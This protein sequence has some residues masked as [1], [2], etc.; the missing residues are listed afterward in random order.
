MSED[1]RRG[2]MLHLLCGRVAAGKSTLAARLAA[3]DRAIVIAEDTWL[4][5]LY[6]G[7]ITTV[8]AYVE[9]AARLRALMG[10]H[11]A[12]LLRG[13]LS[14]VLDFPANTPATRVWMREIVERSGANHR[15][16]VLD[17]PI[18]VCRA[19]MHARNAAGAHEYAP[20][21]AEFDH[22]SSFFVPP[23]ADEGFDIVIHRP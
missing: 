22:I 8:A 7:E 16:H 2:A 9:R 10:P 19:R 21:D 23:G 3:T 1:P 18:E 4:S 15:M 13:G 12:D 11:V 17:T 14:V 5:R 20:T 6:A